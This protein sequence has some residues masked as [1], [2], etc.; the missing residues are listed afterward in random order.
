MTSHGFSRG[1]RASRNSLSVSAISEKDGAMERDYDMDSARWVSDLRSPAT[2]GQR[3]GERS[4]ARLGSKQIASGALPVIFDRRVSNT[5]IS[6][7]KGAITGPAIARGVSFLKD[8]LHT[9][10]FSSAIQIIDD[11]FLI[12]GNGSRPWDGEGVTMSKQA[13][14]KD[15]VLQS[16]LLNS[17]SAKQLK[18]TT[19]GHANRGLGQPPG[20]GASNTILQ[21]GEHSPEALMA[22]AGE[23]LLI[24]EMFGP[25]LNSNTGDY[26]VGV[27]GF[28]I[29]N[30][31]RAYPVSEITI[32]GNLIDI[33]KTLI[34]ANDLVFN[35]ATVVPSLLCEGITIAGL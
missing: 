7:L 32:A 5:L 12:R 19:T 10:I 26:S 3:A 30:G 18:L 31:Q 28:K 20:V 27:A 14:I 29:E 1:W 15:G 35:R 33:Y 24:T 23:G 8:K 9:P 17:A 4:I 16:W 34:P 25:S 21:A 11:P 6:A 2:V 22:Q 13:I